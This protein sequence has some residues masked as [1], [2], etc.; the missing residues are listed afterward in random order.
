MLRAVL[1]DAV[2]T[3]I[4]PDPPVAEAY[5]QVGRALGS[6]RSLMEIEELFRAAYRRSESLF[7]LPDKGHDGL[8]RGPTSEE[9]E[10]ERWRQVIGEVFFDLPPAAA[11]E[12]LRRLWQHFAQ[13]PHW[14]LYSDVAAT[15]TELQGRGYQLGIASNFDSRLL[16]I[17]AALP[18][19]DECRHVFVSSLI[20]WPKPAPQFFLAVESA[21]GVKPQEILL[22]GDDRTNDLLGAANCGWKATL[23]CRDGVQSAEGI[24][25][26]TQLLGLTPRSPPD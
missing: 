18:P 4:Y 25:S 9:R 12:A 3:L 17:C 5:W 22:V 20:G 19:L 23:L 6:V 10:R 21:L 2:G 26:L 14:R 15:W 1:F 16:G 24:A 11:N 8:Q 13:P 7:A